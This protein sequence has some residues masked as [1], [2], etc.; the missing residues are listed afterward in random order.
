MVPTVLVTGTS[1]ADTF[2]EPLRAANCNIDNP[3]YLLSEEELADRLAGAS[4]YLLG[5]DEF[6]S[7]SALANAR[8][9]KVVAFLG[10]GYESF[11]D[12]AAAT[13]LGIAVTNT[14]GTLTQSVAEFTVGQVLNA[15]RQLTVYTNGARAA[16]LGESVPAE[17]KCHDLS[18]LSVGIVGLG[19][20]G[21]RI[22]AMLVNGLGCRVAYYSR[23]RK[24]DV[25]TAL[26]LTYRELDVL[27]SDSDVLIL[28]ASS[29]AASRGMIDRNRLRR[30]RRGGILINTAR[31]DLVTA[32][33][34][35][36]A[37]EG[38]HLSTAVFDGFYDSEQS[39]V[40]RLL[41]FDQDRLLITR[42]IASLTHE[43]RDGMARKAVQS[44]LNVL[45]SGSDEYIVNNVPPRRGPNS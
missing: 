36:D 22:A 26:G 8:Q 28:M 32:D 29:N 43:A 45:R 12:T 10:V 5:G 13:R 40:Q 33:A 4:A 27:L 34:L 35:L 17:A 7:A 25:E 23:T 3:T 24:P 14:P 31:P 42:H 2:L 9:L 20:I 44:I 19:T 37:L 41:A 16:L 11:V 30:L 1:V 21:T 15:T 39:L 38:G 6:A 18:A